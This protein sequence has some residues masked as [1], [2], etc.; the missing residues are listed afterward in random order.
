[1]KAPPQSPRPHYR[2]FH[3]AALGYATYHH[4][5]HNY[6]A[7]GY[8]TYGYGTYGHGTYRSAHGATYE[9]ADESPDR[10]SHVS[11]YQREAHHH[12]AS[13]RRKCARGRVC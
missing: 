7:Y 5:T 8:G 2:G 10:S 4:G 1:M 6:G 12:Q 3:N 11:P 13:H 9:S